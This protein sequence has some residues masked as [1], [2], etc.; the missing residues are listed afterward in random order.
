MEFRLQ[1]EL[2]TYTEPLACLLA[3]RFRLK[4]ELS[5]MTQAE[6][7]ATTLLANITSHL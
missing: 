4:A 5:A 1:A 7:H 6:L 3:E 2:P